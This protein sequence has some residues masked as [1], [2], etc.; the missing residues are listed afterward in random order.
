M[1]KSILRLFLRKFSGILVLLAIAVIGSLASGDFKSALHL[2]DSYKIILVPILALIIIVWNRA[3]IR[4][5][6]GEKSVSIQLKK[7]E[8]EKFKVIN[9]IMLDIGGKTSQIDHLIVSNYGVFV[10]ETKNYSGWIIGNDYD[11]Y[12]T[13]VIYKRKEKLYNPIRQNYGHI[14]ALQNVLPEYTYLNYYSIVAFTK[15]ADL[16]V[17]TSADVVYVKDIF[18]TI[19]KYA[20][21]ESIPNKQKEIIINR[22]QSLNVNS[23]KNR[24]RHVDAI[25]DKKAEMNYKINNDI[26][27]KC[28]SKM[29]IRN[30]KY[31]QFKGCSGY[32]RCKSINS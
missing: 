14:K 16:K 30:G 20:L 6:I 8:G 24:K 4:G 22:L 26:C 28:G 13:Q 31:G 11:D 9:N 10:I 23:R 25:Q 1:S 32:P 21:S 18:H 19:Q 7:L 15:Q 27:P 17:Q 2:V 5:I 12:W 3:K 29:V